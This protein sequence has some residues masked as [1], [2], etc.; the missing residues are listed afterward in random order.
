[1]LIKSVA[2]KG[3]PVVSPMTGGIYSVAMVIV[4]VV[5]GSVVCKCRH[6]TLS[7]F[8]GPISKAQKEEKHFQKEA[9]VRLASTTA[10][11]ATTSISTSTKQWAVD[12]WQNDHL[13]GEECECVQLCSALERCPMHVFLCFCSAHRS[14]FTLSCCL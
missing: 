14:R 2:L 4:P 12:L 13:V 7:Y 9:Q 8:A 1:M 10:A 11:A 5:V 6:L 3:Y